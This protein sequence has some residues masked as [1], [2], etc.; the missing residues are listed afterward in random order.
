[1]GAV[2]RYQET[3]LKSCRLHRHCK[4]V[5]VRAQDLEEG[6]VR[7]PETASALWLGRVRA[8]FHPLR[9]FRV[10]A[11]EAAVTVVRLWPETE[12]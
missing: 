7:E 2:V 12:M 8:L 11:M 10:P 1:M 3:E 6:M 5:P 4:G 9:D